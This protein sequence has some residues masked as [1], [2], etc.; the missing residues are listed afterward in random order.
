MA[1]GA[2]AIRFGFNDPVKIYLKTIRC[3][4]NMNNFK[5][6]KFKIQFKYQYSML[7]KLF[8]NARSQSK[9]G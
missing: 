3:I 1:N 5:N 2:H 9:N 4:R 7:I 6:I 8:I